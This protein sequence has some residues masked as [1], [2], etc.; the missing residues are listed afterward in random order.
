MAKLAR[1][2]EKHGVLHSPLMGR[3]GVALGSLA[4]YRKQVMGKR[5][6]RNSR[7]GRGLRIE[8]TMETGPLCLLAC[9]FVRP[10]TISLRLLA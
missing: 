3:R 2:R 7:T 5:K 10:D 4:C 8:Q 6:P 1:E 9:L